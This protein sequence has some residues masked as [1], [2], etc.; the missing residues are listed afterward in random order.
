[1]TE[2]MQVR[3]CFVPRAGWTF[4]QADYEQLELHTLAQLCIKLFGFSD[5]AV[6][7]NEGRDPHTELAA[8]L[9]GITNE[10]AYARKKNKKDEVF[11]LARQTAKV[12]NFGF[13]GGLGIARF[14]EFARSTY[15]LILTVAEAKKAKQA[16]EAMWREVK[17]FFAHVNEKTQASANG[18]FTRVDPFTGFVRGNMGYC[19][20]CNDGFQRLGA[21]VAKE[22]MWLVSRASY[23][24][25]APGLAVGVRSPLYGCR[26]V[27]F[28]HDEIIAEA[29]RNARVHAAAKELER[30][31]LVAADKYCP[32]VKCKAPPMVMDVWSKSAEACTDENDMLVPWGAHPCSADGCT[33]ID[34]HKV[35]KRTPAARL[36]HGTWYCSKHVGHDI[37]K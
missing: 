27:N 23:T 4:I 19:D 6:V 34:E 14:I 10:E 37:R 25:R 33:Y 5:L 17:P 2:M 1:M 3:D 28:I 32:D 20:G 30:L 29:V 7:L 21:V 31:M 18:K 22:A 8:L 11:Q 35:V 12:A 16:W 24:G 26:P 36:I 9:L 15:Q 13:P